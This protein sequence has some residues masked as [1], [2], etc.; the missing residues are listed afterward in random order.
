[1]APWNEEYGLQGMFSSTYGR[2]THVKFIFYD[3]HSHVW[4]VAVWELKLILTELWPRKYSF[5]IRLKY[6][7]DQNFHFQNLE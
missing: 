4:I 6:T 2:R 7:L 3:F 5:L 1:M